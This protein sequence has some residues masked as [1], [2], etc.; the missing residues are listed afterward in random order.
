LPDWRAPS[1]RGWKLEIIGTDLSSRAVESAQKAIWPIAKAKE[2]PDKYLKR[3]MLKGTGEQKACMK[4]GPEIRSI[5]RCQ[6]LNLNAEHYPIPGMFD[7]IF[8]RNVMIYFDAPSRARVIDR[9]LRHLA[10][11]GYLFVGHAESLHGA[12]AQLRHVIPTVYN[13]TS[14]PQSA[15]NPPWQVGATR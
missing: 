1:A 8:C 3:F 10:L 6:N 12:S 15:A 14:A 13:H 2:I 5:V 11:T 9:L 4:A 7:L